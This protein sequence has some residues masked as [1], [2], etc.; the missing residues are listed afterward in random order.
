MRRPAIA[1]ALAFAIGG[2]VAAQAPAPPGH[3]GQQAFASDTPASLASWDRRTASMIRRGELKRTEVRSSEDGARRDEWFE[4][5]YKGVPVAGAEV[6]RRI[7]A[8]RTAAL[9]GTIYT[10]V[11][12]NPVPKLT[13]AEAAERLATL[14]KGLG[15]GLPPELVVLPTADGHYRLVYQARIFT[16][17]ELTLYSLDAS[18]GDVVSAQAEPDRPPD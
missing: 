6:W 18:S 15:P 7:E 17:V 3:P 8:G 1:P 9:E 2:S 14:G 5:L 11:D 4:Q 10:G 12:L 16:G 13:R